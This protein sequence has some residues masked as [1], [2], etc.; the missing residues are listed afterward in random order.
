ML[1]R[2]EVQSVEYVHPN[3]I[4]KI[5]TAPNDPLYSQQADLNNDGINGKKRGADIDAPEAWQVTTGS[6][7]VV[8]GII[9]TGIDYNHPDLI[10]NIWTN[11][12]ETGLDEQGRDKRF[13]GIDDD[14]N[15]YVDDY[16]GWDFVNNDND[17]MDDNRHGTHVAGTIGAV[18][19]NGV[20]ITG[21]NWEVRMVGL[22]FL[23]GAGS[24]ALSDAV[25]AIEY[26]TMM[27]IPITNNSWGGGGYEATLEA[28]IKAAGDKGF[29]F[30]AAAGNDSNN[31]DA[32]PS[33]PA[34]YKLPNI[35]SVAAVDSD[36]S[37]ANFSNYG[38]TSVHVAAPGVDI[39]STLPNNTYGTLSGTSMA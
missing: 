38:N 4:L 2:S 5:V 20:G 24:G 17:P 3:S 1:F 19:N 37:L 13:N 22:K 35:I 21:I 16:R 30:V 28:A 9:D 11:P 12:G 27:N 14:K 31:N 7:S 25:K 18:G 8:V 15:G 33:Y 6:S 10:N 36:D 39:L 32:T 23:S 34:S 29:L 26:A